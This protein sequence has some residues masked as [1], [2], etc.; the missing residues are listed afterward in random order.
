MYLR[1]FQAIVDFLNL[2]KILPKFKNNNFTPKSKLQ[3]KIIIGQQDADLE[4]IL[5]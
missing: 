5:L 4:K 3:N 2:N 1:R